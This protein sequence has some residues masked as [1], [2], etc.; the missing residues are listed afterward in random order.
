MRRKRP[1]QARGVYYGTKQKDDSL[2]HSTN[3]DSRF[4]VWLVVILMVAPALAQQT[5]VAIVGAHVIPISGPEF[6]N[7]VLVVQGGKIVAAGPAGSTT[8]PENAQR[9]NASGKILMPGIIDS[10]SHIGS[11]GRGATGVR[12]F[13]PMSAVYWTPL[14]S[15]MPASRR[16][17]R[18]ASP[19]L[20]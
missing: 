1:R 15:A 13:S 7:G 17:R 6:D 2:E 18:A 16:R 14:T 19:P 3:S 20:T 8:I 12:P 11:P 5:P 10:H 4:F 9:I